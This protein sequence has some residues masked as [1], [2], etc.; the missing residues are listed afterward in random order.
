[1][2]TPVLESDTADWTALI[3]GDYRHAVGT[4]PPLNHLIGW[5]DPHD[6]SLYVEPGPY[7]R[8]VSLA[9]PF[10]TQVPSDVTR[11]TMSIVAPAEGA[12]LTGVTPVGVQ[13][14]RLARPRRRR[15]ARRRTVRRDRSDPAALACLRHAPGRSWVSQPRGDRVRLLRKRFLRDAQRRRDERVA[16]RIM[17]SRLSAWDVPR[18]LLRRHWTLTGPYLGTLIDHPFP[19]PAANLGWGL[20]HGWAEEIAFGRSNTISGVWRGSFDFPP[21]NYRLAFQVDDGT[22]SGERPTCHR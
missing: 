19:V 14:F 11:P 5:D 18:L 21:D 9:G 22:E 3:L 6:F 2:P 13:S 15:P 12:T 16:G 7:D 4:I 8:R 10:L 17:P 20:R 1:M